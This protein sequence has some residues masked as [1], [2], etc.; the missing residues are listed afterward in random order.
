MVRWPSRLASC[1]GDGQAHVLRG[2]SPFFASWNPAA[3]PRTTRTTMSLAA[4]SSAPHQAESRKWCWSYVP[5]RRALTRRPSLK[6]PA[7]EP[8]RADFH[9]RFHAT[10]HAWR[11]LTVCEQHVPYRTLST[12]SVTVHCNL[13]TPCGLSVSRTGPCVSRD[14]RRVAD[15]RYH[16]SVCCIR[17]GAT[18]Y[19]CS[20]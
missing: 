16:L 13:C 6:V 11:P 1:H 12:L 15:S 20:L 5:L 17:S 19:L 14:V 2:Y 9:H 18:L 3:A 8:A 4:A 10:F 7:M